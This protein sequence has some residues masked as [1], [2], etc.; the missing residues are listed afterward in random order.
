MNHPQLVEPV[1][2]D[3]T[4]LRVWE[5]MHDEVLHEL[6]EGGEVTDAMVNVISDLVVRFDFRGAKKK[7]QRL[8]PLA[9]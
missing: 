5:E 1:A 2:P 4:T 3:A 8:K 7:S 6:Q 9:V